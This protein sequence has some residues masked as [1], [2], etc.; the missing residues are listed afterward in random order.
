MTLIDIENYLKN[1]IKNAI[2]DLKLKDK[3][4]NPSNISVLT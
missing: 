3:N 1:L 4:G 2:E